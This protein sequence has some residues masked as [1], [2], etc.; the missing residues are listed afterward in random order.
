MRKPN[1]YENTTVPGSFK[2]FPAGGYVCDIVKMEETKSKAGKPML[3]VALEISEGE[4]A[5]FFGNLFRERRLSSNKPQEVKYPNEGIAY[6][7][8][9]DDEG[10]CNRNFK[11]F[12]TALEESGSAVWS[13][14][15]KLNNLTG[16]T[17]GVIFRR[18]EDE[19]NGK[20]FWKTRP[21]SFRSVQKIQEGDFT[22][23]DDKYLDINYTGTGFD[24]TDTF[25]AAQDDI[26]F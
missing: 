5:G 21:I 15:D 14:D 20:T 7:L 4:Y 22:V 16:L 24:Q 17:V 2:R 25:V 26:P 18:E 6:I 13:D 8:T 3:K 12:C 9:E 10:N 19:Y 11:G 1:N 23:P